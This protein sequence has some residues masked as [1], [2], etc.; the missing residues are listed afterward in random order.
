MLYN[1]L[2]KSKSVLREAF[3]SPSVSDGLG[4]GTAARSRLPGARPRCPRAA[5]RRLREL[6]ARAG[7]GGEGKGEEGAAAP[8]RPVPSRRCQPGPAAR[9]EAAAVVLLLES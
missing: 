2:L 5:Q 4:E 9:R 3:C 8:S 6:R 1:P 7:Q